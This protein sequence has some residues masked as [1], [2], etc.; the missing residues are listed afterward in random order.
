MSRLQ[1]NFRQINDKDIIK[2]ITGFIW[3]KGIYV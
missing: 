2:Q 1:Y 3:Q